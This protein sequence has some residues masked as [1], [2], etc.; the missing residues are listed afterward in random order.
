MENI[1]ENFF[2]KKNFLIVCIS[3]VFTEFYYF[4]WGSRALISNNY[5]L[6]NSLILFL[7]FLIF[8]IFNFNILKKI[9]KK[10]NKKKYNLLM[11]IF[12]T[13]IYFKIIQILL[14]PIPFI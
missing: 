3:I 11:I 12:L 7:F 14:L 8:F 1:H 9:K 10:I 13:F 5:L 6:L 2:K 4:N